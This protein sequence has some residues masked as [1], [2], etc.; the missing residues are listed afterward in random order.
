M[1]LRY[2]TAS[3]CT[4]IGHGISLTSTSVIMRSKLVLQGLEGMV[5]FGGYD[6]TSTFGDVWL[7]S[8]GL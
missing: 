3:E 2:T 1:A 7:L 5:V 6:G 8:F 4:Y